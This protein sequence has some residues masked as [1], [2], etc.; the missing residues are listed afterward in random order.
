MR[1]ALL[2]ADLVLIP[3]QPS[4]FDGRASGEML[5]LIGEAH[6]FR[7][8]LAARFVL[9]RCGARTIIARE[10]AELLVD[11]DPPVLGSTIGQR[12]GFA[13]AARSGRLLDEI[14]DDGPAARETASLTAEIER[15]TMPPSGRNACQTRFRRPSQRRGIRGCRTRDA[16]LSRRSEASLFAARLTIDVTLEQRNAASKSSLPAAQTDR[17]RHV[18]RAGRERFPRQR[19]R[20][21]MNAS[22]ATHA[23]REATVAA[24]GLTHHRADFWL[25]KRIEHWIRFGRVAEEKF[26]DRRRRIV[27]FTPGGVFAFV[28]WAS[29]DFGTIISRIDIVRTVVAGEPYATLPFV[30]PGGD[31]LL[32]INGWPKVNQVL[33]AIDVVEASGVDPADAAPDHWRH[34]HN[35]LTA[36]EQPRPYTLARHKSWLMRRGLAP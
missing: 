18:A 21:P 13:D 12:I 15:S 26:L 34:V 1:S 22:A 29:N 3:A 30:R 35:R 17:R 19:P 32:R 4:P 31:I 6:I 23:G 25:E 7:P 8:Q 9:I 11:H 14:D 33:Q 5:K 28:R 2:A 20:P 16:L 24:S 36:G 10:T 27:S